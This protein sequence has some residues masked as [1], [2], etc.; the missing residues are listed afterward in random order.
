MAG[1]ARLRA[2]QGVTPG[3]ITSIGPGMLATVPQ[4]GGL[5]KLMDLIRA[6]NAAQAERVASQNA[7]M[8]AI[9]AR[10]RSAMG[11]VSRP[12][13]IAEE[14]AAGTLTRPWPGIYKGPIEQGRTVPKS[15]RSPRTYD[16]SE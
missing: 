6:R 14:G 10:F 1:F 3:D 12:G 8:E 13:R 7:L 15:Y 5:A 11:A 9:L 2:P 16:L 4:A